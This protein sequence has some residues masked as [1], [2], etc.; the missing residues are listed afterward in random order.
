MNWLRIGEYISTDLR[1]NNLFPI[2]ILLIG[3]M[4]STNVATFSRLYEFVADKHI[5][6]SSRGIRYKHRHNDVQFR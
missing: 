3:Y 6:K 5:N 1:L 4:C 2:C